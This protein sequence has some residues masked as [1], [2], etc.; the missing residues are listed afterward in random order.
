[1]DIIGRK[2]ESLLLSSIYD[3]NRPEFIAIY[4]RRRIGK[5]YL[6][7]QFFKSKKAIFFNATGLEK[8][9]MKEQIS[10][11]TDQISLIFHR[12]TP[13]QE[14]KNW[15][16]TFKLLSKELDAIPKKK[17]IILFLDELPWMATQHS[18]FLENLDHYWNQ[19]WSEDPRIKLIICGSSASWIIKKIINQR[20]GLHNRVTRKIRL[21]PFS[22]A[23]TRSYLLHNGLKLNSAQILLIYMLLGGVP[24]YLNQ[25]QKEESAIQTLE[26]LSSPSNDL[27]IS[28]F[29]NL[30]ASLFSDH[31]VHVRMVRELAQHSEGLGQMELLASMGVEHLGQSGLKKINELEEAG[32]IKKFMPAFSQKKGAYYRLI[33]EYSLFYLKWIEPHQE[34]L[35]SGNQGFWQAMQLTPA[36]YS[37]LGYA[38]EAVCFKHVQKIK[39]VLKLPAD[40]LSSSWRYAPKRGSGYVGAQIDLLFDRNDGAVT[41]CEIKYSNKP[42]V[43]DKAY[44]N[45]LKN[46][47]DVFKKQ[48][49]TNKQIFL[50]LISANGLAKNEYS[51]AL[52]SG[53]VTLGDLF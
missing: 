17:K 8:G 44:A 6:I 47:M 39:E 30:Y 29:N 9:N 24:Y 48:T 32:F 33:D 20:G 41:L 23:E 50:V 45:N 46:K 7:R 28:E 1:M 15:K 42:F 52:I 12:G 49:R 3:S 34:S 4:G 2:S 19:F 5:T 51:E 21:L 26:S 35:R 14:E 13:I 43:I 10:N 27:L 38:F 36:W 53:L 40:A 16:E 31:E 37:W 11:F 18:H 25:I 22:L